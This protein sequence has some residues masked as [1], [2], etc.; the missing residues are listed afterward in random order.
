MVHSPQNADAY[1]THVTREQQSDDLSPTV[2]LHPVATR[3]SIEDHMNP[4][5]GVALRNQ[6]TAW[7]K[8]MYKVTGVFQRALFLVG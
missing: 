5:C 1:I 4:L 2:R 3:K 7:R 6:V 8:G